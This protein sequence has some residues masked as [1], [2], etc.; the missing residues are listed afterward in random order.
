MVPK[1]R[2]RKRQHGS[3]RRR[4]QGGSWYDDA[5]GSIRDTATAVYQQIPPE[6]LIVAR[7]LADLHPAIGTLDHA[8][9]GHG[10][11]RLLKRR[12]HA[13]RRK[14]PFRYKKH[15]GGGPY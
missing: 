12:V 8:L 3:G 6:A 14:I 2:T 13:Y 9:T 15:R 5:W 11:R 10:R 7:D 1:R 4:Q